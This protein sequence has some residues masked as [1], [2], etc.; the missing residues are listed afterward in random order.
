MES[1][2]FGKGVGILRRISENLFIFCYCCCC[3]GL[4]DQGANFMKFEIFEG[5]Y[6]LGIFEIVSFFFFFFRVF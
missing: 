6:V 5:L 4:V 2:H 3:K 1:I